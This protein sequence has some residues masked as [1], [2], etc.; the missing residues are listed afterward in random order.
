MATNG[1]LYGTAFWGGTSN[2]GT[3]FEIA[4]SGEVDTLYNFCAPSSCTDGHQPFA[5]L[6]QAADGS[7]CGTTGYGGRAGYCTFSGGCGTVFKITPEG[8]L[9]TLYSFCA[10]PGCA[11]G[12]GPVGSLVQA[13]DGNFY[14]ATVYGGSSCEGDGCGTL[15]KITSE[16]TLTTLYSFHDTDGFVPNGGLVQATDGNLY[17]TTSLGGTQGVGTLFRITLQGGLTT[18]Y[19]FCAQTGCTDGRAPSGALIQATDGNFY[20]VTSFGGD[21]PGN[22]G[23]TVFQ[24]SAGGILTTLHSFDG[25]DGI[26]P[27][28]GLLQATSG[29]FYGTTSQGGDLSCLHHVGC[30]TVFSLS[31]GLTPFVSFVRNPAKVGQTFGVLGQ[32]FTGTASVSLNGISANFTVVSD[33][34]I[35]ATVPAGATTGYVTVATPSGTLTSNVPFHLI[36]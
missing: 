17:G 20:G 23:G 5:G 12:E 36:P 18:L 21:S 32:G 10:Q 26:T 15:F 28:G 7:F 27:V 25:A 6:T 9:T 33:T 2:Y 13:T 29:I 1:N 3:I 35:K 19:N 30:G 34:L 14:G 8:V 24:F 11:D 31:T 22:G 4:K 16:G